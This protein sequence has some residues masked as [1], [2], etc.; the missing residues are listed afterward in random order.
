MTA[1]KRKSR[2]AA[3]PAH[4]MTRLA[5]MAV[6][7]GETIGHRSLMLAQATGNPLAMADPEFTRM[8][9]E[10]M[11]VAA[12]TGADIATRMA[13]L[14]QGWAGWMQRQAG[15][16]VSALAAAANP[17]TAWQ[18]WFQLGLDQSAEIGSRL[19]GDAAALADASLAPAHRVVSANARRLGRPKHRK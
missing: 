11:A 13:A 1:R 18:H 14:Q 15:L 7:A 8:V 4:P 3:A 10:K 16:G 17:A 2:R 6:A 12:E 19:M 9:T 5:E